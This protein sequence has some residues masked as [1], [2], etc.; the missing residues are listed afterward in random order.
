MFADKEVGVV[1]PDSNESVGREIVFIDSNVGDIQPWLQD[2]RPGSEIVVLDSARSGLAQIAAFMAGRSNIDAIHII[3]HGAQGQL[4]LGSDVLTPETLADHQTELAAIGRALSADGDILLYG[5]NIAAGTD[6][7]QTVDLLASLT[8]ADV[9]AS[10]DGT[11]ATAQGGDWTLEEQQGVIDARSLSAPAWDGLLV[12]TTINPSG[13]VQ[14]DG[15]D[16]LR[17][18]VTN[19]GQMQ[20]RYQNQLQFFSGSVTDTSTQLFNGMYMAVGTQVIGPDTGAENMAKVAWTSAGTQ[21]LTGTGTAADPFVVTTTMFYNANGV[22]GYQAAADTLA[23]VRTSYISGTAYFTNTVTITPP[24]TNTADIKWYQAADTLLG[25]TDAGPAYAVAPGIGSTTNVNDNISVI[26]TRQ[27]AGTASERFVGFAEVD[28][29][30]QFDRFY[31]GVYN[32][33]GLYGA[34]IAGGGN[35]T[36]T[37]TT[38][39]STDNGLGVQFNLGAINSATTFSYR[40][41]FDST[42]TLDLDANNSTATG[43][44]YV[45]TYGVGSGTPVKVVDS[46]VAVANVVADISR[47]T[48]TINN[49]QSGDTLS[50]SGALPA[51]ITA[52]IVGSTLTLT[53]SASEAAYQTALQQILFNSTSLSTV[54]RNLTIS[55]FNEI[56]S[57]ATTASATIN[58]AAAPVV[59]LNSGTNQ[60]QIITNGGFTTDLSGWTQTGT[61]G[62]LASSG[63]NGFAWTADNSTGTLRQTG[64]TGWNSGTAP[65]GA[66][67]LTFELGWN[68]RNPDT[69]AAATLDISVGGVVYARITTGINGSNTATITYMNGAS[70]S[71]ASVTSSTFGSWA[72]TGITINLPAT[73][74]ATGDL[75]FSYASGSGGDDIFIDGVSVQTVSDVTPGV[76]FTTTYTEN[77][78]GVSIADT[79][80]DVRDNDSTNMVSAR[81]VLTN[82]AAGDVL[83]VGSL[84]AGITASVDTSV[85]GQITVTLTGSATRASYAAAIRAITFSNTTDNPSTTPRTVNVTVN[86]GALDSAVA[87]TT[88]NVIAVNDA[89]VNTVPGARTTNE[90]ATL[91]ITGVS[92]ADPDS[93]TLTTTLTVTNGTL[94]VTAGGGATISGNGSATVTI[95]GTVAQINAALAGLT[96]INTPDYNGPAQLTISTNDGALTDT[97]T[98]A[99]TVTPVADITNDTVTTNE[100]TPITFN[101]ITGSNGASADSFENSGRVVTSVTQPAAG[102]GTVTFAADG[103]I[104][105][106]PPANF[107]G[108]TTFTYTVTSGGVTETATVTVNVTAVNDAPVNTVPAAQT[109]AEDTPKAIT[110]VSVA[111]VDSG[112]LTTTLSVTN[113]TLAVAAG[114]GAAITGNGSGT[115]TIVGTAAQINAALLGLTYT[116]TADYNGPAQLTVSTSD[117]ALTDVDTV[118]ITVTPVADITNDTVTTAEDTPI[119]FN[120]I[121]GTNGASADSFEN[122]GRAVT[123]VTQ[124][125]A[126]QGTVTFAADGTITYTPATNFNGVATFTYTVTSGGVTETATVTVNVTA[127]NDAPVNTV[128]GPQT[129]AEDTSLAIPGVS[130]SD[131]DNASLTTTLTVTNGTLSVTAGGGAT[132]A[133]NGSSVVT[134]AGTAAQINAALLGLTYTNTAD[135]NGPAQLT[136]STSDGALTD[137]DTVAITVTPVADITNDT[138]A[139]A[140]DTPISFN[141]ITGTNGAT[142]D[143]FEN[144]GRVVTSVTQPPAGQGTVT[145]AAD[146]TL[147]YTPAANFNGTTSFTYTVTSGGVTETATVTV[148][149]TAV[150][151][152]PVNTVPGPRTTAEDTPLAIAGVSV[153]DVDSGALT[154]TLTVTNGTLAV[155]AGGGATITGNGTGTVTVSGTAAQINAALAGL[156]Y[157]NTADYNGP[158]Q[159]TVSTSD[160]ALTDVDT[161]AI[162]V[163][164]VADIVN[165]T[166]TTAEDTPIT[167]NVITGTNGASVD[168][169]ENTGRVVTSVTQP[170]QGS[171]TFA[172]DG[173]IT[174]TPPAN[175]NGTTSF[176][177]TVTSGGVTETAT[178]TVNVTAVNDA[179]VNTVPAAQT[180]AEDTPLAITGVSVADVDSGALTTTLTVT[181]GTLAVT[182][183]GGATITGNGTGTVTVSGTAAQINAALLGLTYTN[184]A[185]YNGPA[186]LT[187]STSDGVLTDT[188][189]VAI[190]VTPVADITNDTVTTAEDTPITFNV[191]TGSNGASADSFENTGRVVSSV[192]QPAAGQGTVTFAADGTITYTP[193]SNFNGTTSF[194]YTVTSG[195]VTET[196]TVTLNVTAV[197]DAPVNTV[198]A[199]QT[200]AE[201]TPLAIPSV[202]VS[203][204]D[205]GTL[206]T[207][208]TVTNGTLT[209]TA[210]GGAGI[211]GN[212]GSTVTIT[213]TAAQI[214]AA[215]LGLTYTN[216]ADY[217]G[218]AQL[219]V[220]T[221]D[222][223]LTDTDTVGITVTPV[224]DITNDTVT[225]NEDTPITFNVIT[226]SNGATVDSFENAG[227]VVTS[228]TQPAAGQGTVTFA[229]D[230]TIT[231]TPAANFNGVATFTYTV[232]SGGVTETA[233]VTVNVT[234][235]ND[236]P[237]NTVPVAQ[238]TAEDTAL[239][240]GG[241]SV[242]DVDGGTLTTTLT[243]TSGTLTVATG[244]GAGIVGNGGST[245]TITGTAAQINAALLGLTYTNTADY[246]GPDTLTVSTTDGALTDTDTVAITVTPVADITND[247]VTT[248]EDTPITFNVIT[249]SDGATVDS[250]EN[251]GR[252]VT[253]VTQP[254]AGQGT[255]TF[256]A[257]GTITYT[258]AANFNGVATFTY[259]VTSGGVTETATVTVNV[260]AQ[261]DAPVN[262]VPAAQTTAEDTPLAIP[263]VSVSD[264]DGGPLTTTL[265][266]ANG[267]LSITAGGGAAVSGSGTATVTLSGT[268]AQINAALASLTYTNT[269]DYNG[270]DTL[271]VSTSDGALTDVDTVAIT[272]TPVVDVTND[273]VTTNEDAPISF[274][275]LTGTNGASADSFENSGRVV[276]SVT[277]PAAGQGTVTFAA[278]GTITYTPAAN[279][280]GT[281]TFTYTV[282]SGGVTETATVTVNVTAVND[283]PVNTVPATAQ[284]TEEDAPLA[285]GNVTVSD[286]DGGALTTTLTVANGTLAVA[287]G[288]GAG[289]T[290][291]GSGTVT[292]TGTAAQINAALLGLTYTNTADYNGP[293]TLTVSTSDGVLTDTDTVAITVTPVADITNDTVTTNEDTPITFNVLTGT[294]GASEDSFE[295]S[296]RAVT[297]VTQPPSG[298]GTVT[299]AADGT[300][301]YT[302]PADFN[303]TTSFTY[304][305]TSGGVTETATVTVNVTAQNDAPTN[306]VPGPRTTAEDSPLPISGVSVS[307]VD[308]GTL[309][310][311]LTVINGTLSV[312][313]SG[314]AVINGNGS[315]TVTITGTAAEINLALAGLTYTNTADYNGPDTLTV[316]TTDGALTDTDTVAITVTPV[317]DVTD[318]TV[319]TT[320]DTPITFNVITGS[321]GA[322]ADSFENDG[323]VVTSVTQPAPGQGTVTFAADGTITYTPPADFNGTTSFTYTVTSGGVTETATVTVNVTAANDAPVNTVPGPRTTAEDT[324]LAITGVSV[325]DVDSV[326]LTTT[327]TVT[328]GTLTVT[329]GGGAG[330]V[331]NGSNTV[332]LTGTAAQINAAL[333]G[334]TY[335]NTADYNGP[336]QLTVTTSDGAL[337]DVDTVAITVTPVDDIANDAVT[338]D[339]DTPVTISVLTNDS[340]ENPGRTITAVNG[341]SIVVGGSVTV[342]NGTVRLNGDGTLTFSP[343]LNFNGPTSFT[344][345]V[346][347]GGDTET[348]TVFVTVTAVEDAPVVTVPGPQETAEDTPLAIDS[349]RVTVFD[350]DDDPLTTTLTVQNGTL[351]VATG[352]GAG[353][354]GNGTGTVTITGTAAEINAAL[355][356]LTYTNVGDYNG[357]DLLQV[358]TN[359]GVLTD[360]ADVT[361]TVTAVAD[362]AGDN[363]NTDEDTEV[364]ISV[365]SNDSFENPGRAI[366]AV[367]GQAITANGPAIAVG[368]GTVRLNGAGQLIFLP[369]LDFTGPTSF[370][371][372]VT[373]GGVME[374]ASVTVDVGT[375][376][377]APVNTVPGVQTMAEDAALQITGVSVSDPDGAGEPLT[378]TLTV[379][380]GTLSVTEGGGATIAGNN[381]GTVTITGTAAQINA[382]LLGLTYR[383]TADYNGPAQLTVSTSDGALTDV[384]TVA[385]TVTPVRDIDN[386]AVTTAEDT[387]ATID[388]LANDSFENP[389]STITAINGQSIVVG[390][391]VAVANGTVRLNGDGT[392]T[393]SPTLNFNGEV[394]FTY[395]VTSGGRTETATVDVTVTAVN[396]AP[397]LTIPGAQTTDEDTPLDID[398]VRVTVFDADDDVLTTTLSVANGTVFVT[399]GG[400]A[401]V[402]ANGTATVTIVGT[403]TQVNAALAGLRYVNTGDYNGSDVMTVTV[404]DGT[405]DDG[406]TVAITVRPVADITNDTVTTAE[407]TPITFNV[408]TGSNGASAD[409]F[410]N[411]SRVVTS[412]TQPASGQGTVTFAADGTLTYTPPANFNG[413]TTFTYT[414]TSGG[415]TETATVTVNV[416]AVND[417]P[418]GTAPPATTL[419]DTP[420][421]GAVTAT[422]VDGDTLTFSLA[423]GPAQGT[424]L[425]NADGTYT[426]TPN[427]NYN[428]ADSFTVLVDDG[429]GGTT[430]VTVNVTVTPVNDNP[431]GTAPPVTTPEDTPV[432]GAVT[433][434]DVD[435]DTLTLSLAG[436]PAQGTVLVNADGTYTYTPNA[437]YNGPDSFTVLVDDGHGGTTTVTVNVTVTPENDAPVGTAPPAT[438]PEDTPVSGAVTA[439]DVDGDT[440]T[441]S[442]AGG[443]A[444]GTVLVNADGTYTYTPNANYNGPDSFTVLVDD[445][446][447]GTTTVTVN[448]TVTPV[449]D[450]PVATAPPVTTPE[451]TPV[452]G[453]V[454]ATDVDGDTL[455]FSLDSGPAQGTV[456][457]NA[458]GTYTYT[459]NANYNGADSFTVL[460]DDGHGGRTPVTVNVTVTPENDVPVNTVPVA[461]TTAEDALLSIPGV[462]VSDIDGGAL[463]TTL[464]VT[465]GTLTVA[466]GGGAGIV[467]NGGSTVTITGTA[468]EINLALAGLTYRNTADYNGPDTLTV[469]TTDGALTDTDTVGIT[470]SP[471]ADITDDTVTTDEDTPITFNVILGSNGATVDSFEN[472]GRVVTSVTQPAPGQGTVTFSADGTITYT[473]PA[474]FNGTTTFTYTVTSGGVTETATV[475]VNVTA[476]NDAP[477]NAVPGPQTTAED[478]P[479]SIPDV[480]VSDIDGGTLTTTLT[481]TNGTLS[482]TAGGG[483]L[484]SGSGTGTVVIEGTAAQINAALAGL[485]YRNTADYNGPA[486]LTVSTTDGATTDTDT[487]AITVT[488]VADITNDTVT[489][490]ED[491]PITFNV[492]T[493]SNGASE[494]SFENSG[495]VVTSVTQPAAGQGTV[496]FLAD[497]TITYT[498]PADFNG[499]TTFTYTVTSGGVTETATVTVNVTAQNDAPVNTV[500]GS[501]E[502][503]EDTLLAIGGVSV[504]D[505]DGGTLTTTLTVTNGTLSVATGGGAVINGN[506]GATVTITGTAAE[507]NLALAGLTYTNTADYNGPDTLTVSTS[508]GVLT[509]TDTVGIAVTPVTDI[510]NDTVTTDEDTPIT[511]NV[512]LGS[513]G[514]TVDSFENSGR[515]VSSV[516]QP[517][518]GQG[519][520]TFAADGTITYTP[521]A[522][523]NGTTTFTYTVTSG[524]VTET[525]TVTVNVTAVN[526]EP[527]NAVPG[528]QTTAED[529]LLSIPGVSVADVDGGTLTTTL[530][531]TSGTLTVATGGGAGIT[532][533]GSGTVTITGTAAD[534]NLALAGLTYRNTADYNGPDTLTVSTS[535]GVLTD[536]DTVGITVTPV[537]D[538]TDD[539]VTTNEDTPIT[540]NVITGSNGASEDSFENSGRVVTSVT[541]PAPGQG[542][543]VF[544]ADGTITYTPPADFNGTTTFTYTVTSGGVTETATVT[545]NVTA[546]NDA[547][548][549]AVPVAQTTAEDSPLPIPGVSVSD[550]DGGT[551][552]TTLT[553]ANGTLTVATGGGAGIV[554]NGGSTVT[555]TGTAL[556]INAALAGLIYTNTA[557]YNGPDTL[558]VSTSDGVLTDTDTVAITVTPVAD[559]TNDTVTTN[560]D[561]PI[562]FNVILG[563][564]G[565]TV[566]SFENSGRVVTSV[567]QPAPGQGTV[568]FSADGTITY[569]PP[570]DFNG[571]T[572]FTY[573]VTSG[574]VTETATVTVN[575]TAQNDAP[576]NTVPATAQETEEDAP[577]AIGGVTVSDVDGGTLTTTLTVT[578]GTLSVTAGGGALISGSGTGTVVI[579][580]T[581]AQINAALAG[582]TY[583]NTADYN[584][585]DTLTV[586][587]T[588]G[589]LTDTDTVAITVTPVADITNDT[590]TTNEDTPITFNVLTGT[591]GASADSFENAGHMVTAVTQPPPGQGSVSFAADGTI[592]YTPPVNF[593]GTTSFTYTVSS[594]GVTETATVTV[595]VTAVNDAPV[596]VIPGGPTL[597]P[598]QE[599]APVSIPGVTVS[600]ID[601]GSLTTTLSVA[602]GTLSVTTGGGAG[603]T[604]NGTGSVTITGTAAEINAA[605]AGLTYR[606][607]ADYNGPDTLTVSTSDGALDTTVTA[608]ITV[609]PVVDVT[610]D[611]V[612]TAED[613]PIS[614]NVLTGTNGAS[615][616]SF[617]NTGRVVTS[618]TQP[619]AGQGTVTFLADGTIT[620][621][622]PANFNGTTTFTYTVTSGGVTETATVTVNVASVNDAPVNTVPGPQETDEDAQ[623]AIPGVTVSDV[624]GD[625]LTTTLTVTNGTLSVAAGGGAGI[626]GEGTGT[627]TLTGTAAQINAAL[628]G[629]TYTNTADYNGPAQLTIS[630]TDGAA[631]DTDTVAITVRPVIDIDNDAVTTPEDTPATIDVLNNDSFENT[632]RT[633]V[634]INGQAI[635]VDGSVTVANGTVR[636]N[637]DNTLTFSPNLNFNGQITFTYSVASGGD[638]E[639]ATVTVTVTPVNDAPVVTVP[640]AQTTL[641]DRPLEVDGVR[642]IVIDA[643]DDALTTTVTVQNGTLTVSTGGGVV[644]SGNGTATVTI[645]G[646]AAQINAALAD[647]VYTSRADYNG[648]DQMQVRTSDGTLEGTGSVTIT[649]TPVADIDDDTVDTDEDTPVIV[650]VLT[651]DSFEN[652]GRAITAVDGQTITVGAT[653]N[654]ANGTV[655]LNGDGTLTFDPTDN[656][657]GVTSFTYTVTSGGVTE[658]ATVT[659]DVGGVNDTPQNT[660]PGPQPVTEDTLT[661]IPG[662]SVA[663]PDG[664]DELL[665][666]TLTVQNGTLSVTG[667]SGSGTSTV[668]LTGTAAQ[669]NA[670]LATLQYRGTADYNGPDQLRISTTDAGGLT[671]IDTV[672]ITVAPVRDI[673]DDSVVTREDTPIAISV[674]GNDTFSNPGRTITAVDGF[675]ITVGGPAI[676]VANGTV[677]LNSAGQLVFTPTAN[678]NGT[679]TFTYAVQSNGDSETATVTVNV[680]AENDPP[681]NTVPGAQETAEDTPLAIDGVRVS[682]FDAEDDA[683]TTTL[684]VL[685]GTLTVAAGSGAGV[686]GDGTGTVI[687]TGTAAQINAA[688][689]GLTYTSTAD[690]NGA[691]LMTVTTSDGILSDQDSVAITVRPAVDITSDAVTTLEDTPITFNVLT[692][693]NGASADTFTN[694]DRA[695]TAVTQPSVGQVTFAADG[696]LTY[697]PLA[698]FHGQVSFTYTV[699]SGGVTETATVTVNVTS[700]NDNPVVDPPPGPVTTVEDTPVSGRVTATDADGDALTYARDGGPA[701]GSVVV[702]LDGTYTYTPNPNYFGPDSFTVLVSDGNGGTTTV[703]INVTVTPV[704]DPPV[705]APV[706]ATTPEDTPVSGAVVATDP[707]G[708]ALTYSRA[709]DPSNGTVMVNADGTFIYTPNANYNGADSFTVL[710]DDGHGGTTTVAVSVTVTPVNDAP[711]G[712]A[713]PV[714][715]LEDTPVNGVV[716]GTDVDGDPLTFT[717]NGGPSQGTVVVNPDGTYTYTPNPNANGP[718]SFTVLVDDGNGGTTVVTVNVTVTPVN[719]TPVATAPPVTTSED[720]PVSGAV[721]ATDA[722][723]DPL[724]FTLDTGPTRGTVVINPD[725]T[726]TYTPNPNASG[727]DSFTVLVDDGQGG[728]T[729]VTVN[730]TVTPVNDVPVVTS[731]IATQTGTD[732]SAIRPLD[733]SA[734]FADADGEPLTY[735][736]TGL[737]PGLSLD[738]VTGV[739]SGTIDRSASLSGPFTVT[740]TATDPS[741]AAVSQTFTWDVANPAPL[742][743]SDSASTLQGEPTSG[744]VL[745]NDSDPD[746]DPLDVVAFTVGGITYTAGQ[747]ADIAGVGTLTIGADGS[748]AFTP[749][750]GFVGSVPSITYTVSDGQGGTASASL[751]ITVRANAADPIPLSDRHVP[752]LPDIDRRPDLGIARDPGIVVE[753]A[754]GLGSLGS[755]DG[756]PRVGNNIVVNVVNRI[757][758]L[759][760]V[761]S[762]DPTPQRNIIDTMT[763]PLFSAPERHGWIRPILSVHEIYG[764]S[765]RILVDGS[766]DRIAHAGPPLHVDVQQRPEDLRL[767]IGDD[768]SRLFH[769]SATLADGMP[770]PAGITIDEDQAITIRRDLVKQPLDLM[771][772]AQAGDQGDYQLLLTIDPADGR[773][774]ARHTRDVAAASATFD[775]IIFE[776]HQSTAR[777]AT[778]LMT[779]L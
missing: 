144:G 66:A 381:S 712:S 346:T 396:D 297:S 238:T 651:N 126:G 65:S 724:T 64:I 344:Y 289:I 650:S 541:Q 412:V 761:G 688:L 774:D 649:V 35:I 174:Y 555:I 662:L 362:I 431:V 560:E 762:M 226:G 314:G 590:V 561:T 70:G 485:T 512:I 550:V 440:L 102:Q 571:T 11:G 608:N 295:N 721:T 444:Q 40:I 579:E 46:D 338:T 292:I 16:G 706:T 225:T 750:A 655:R 419:E 75:L 458:D 85:A 98:V 692:G 310:T 97:D 534:I 91:A 298:Q 62:R 246:N 20:V 386:D 602:N 629:L 321:N 510:T 349:V 449:N 523:F 251:A 188:D 742:V 478:T 644:V 293:D 156:T 683:L 77:G 229:A 664:A 27:N 518:A 285:I 437:N 193:P 389:G 89:P 243:V 504:A 771:L 241:V 763:G 139:T 323:R 526:D 83:N 375:D 633:I 480:S 32:G 740:V 489:T 573:T 133:G 545:V 415:V 161:V 690:Y 175:F 312:G 699:T 181:N 551:L 106:T 707:E 19:L 754:N 61:G 566:D 6:G 484:I 472:S 736:A 218:P 228:V 755:I 184:T 569:T 533:N 574:G 86:D 80:N 451:D 562:T 658:T 280:N 315:S 599:D 466:T 417:D 520:V 151:D 689:A 554:G 758:R 379:T 709:S 165:D 24:S 328:N 213:G 60:T 10:T 92:I 254:A 422:D 494:D 245:V 230:G 433:A 350:A 584:G 360:S 303:G 271:T 659:V 351:T 500:P 652:P 393:F 57:D 443:P 493:G 558:T 734:G 406:G 100:D 596:V 322:S 487:V 648:P 178:V 224:A 26:A 756:P 69:A 159:L 345:S 723:G 592:T 5:C 704:N 208:L 732:G 354:T 668:V 767:A 308:S 9:A 490:N 446:H 391:D 682:V 535:D 483:A 96:Y 47:A 525:A 491:T 211:V 625:P 666:T 643:D 368:N 581:A 290:G 583:R 411:T 74:A 402:T 359:D 262:A 82:A 170:S 642:V 153:A 741:G 371:Y 477:V 693:T 264:V 469:S 447:G 604:G 180:T 286:V 108:T 777:L 394:S 614:F 718:D 639:T 617:E 17:I 619:P 59:D 595:N 313:T 701:N 401:T 79:D 448:V 416:T 278:D 505:V 296:G 670:A 4:D 320:E 601:S 326:S 409:S 492:I 260:T 37:I 67:Q 765:V 187:V 737:P 29:D 129:T 540:F 621:T 281:A 157:T 616:D 565:A 134:I 527:V 748:Y 101:V 110:G 299:F 195:G 476:Q 135:Y 436:G 51:G 200:T 563:S 685:H 383:N 103:T 613:T 441:F 186:Q 374:T 81:I 768:Q 162:T 464:T 669:I 408:I 410:E 221:S 301:T 331:G 233:T 528:P 757:D 45:T 378:T 255:V 8:S 250:F 210:G 521:P 414:V 698:N 34:G 719:D 335:T 216:T 71:P 716:I 145:F 471:V 14:T 76:N 725:G 172:A 727:P 530:T 600:D 376:N 576:V 547:P 744:N 352:G 661:P 28:G 279:F 779:E 557:D 439:T 15:S 93:S 99:I 745:A 339:E 380:N 482:V 160:G 463:T 361:I 355:A 607:T 717:L 332:V 307:D 672:A 167:F 529:A 357:P 544:A 334:L 367:N 183:G 681:V 747:M 714:T 336:A 122:A 760:V 206:T 196:A 455:T 638:V 575:V 33:S 696:T 641:E 220:S 507:I 496:T 567:T 513:N 423:G 751:A 778:N 434:T 388:V 222:G 95:S 770:L 118:G 691:D 404:S 738:P 488:P 261:N 598:V 258:P 30:R 58:V 687:L 317:A 749:V 236:A 25:G 700:V 239:A 259:T 537:A 294:N 620:Y 204:V 586:S 623:L 288:G 624:D 48:V 634:A 473:P 256:A 173:T 498:P 36:N 50:V 325:S 117:G 399:E 703:T 387:P 327:L 219:T 546:V 169:F 302:P 678:F 272:V 364:T 128:P 109:T 515:V 606:N 397:V 227:R 341:Q 612:T 365:L 124:P 370:T 773:I 398:G 72:R 73:V 304:T 12:Q 197:N 542:T 263:G 645:S 705:S 300:I 524:G 237:A 680:Q 372:T 468:A 21:T 733:V 618:V 182:A 120:V 268:A 775:Q 453:A 628:A 588:D 456:I 318:D 112:S 679:T 107:N 231:Y 697:T 564:N 146:G 115:V 87:T 593:N 677:S 291:N 358:V 653:V 428:G 702:N 405:L 552:T 140:E 163:T 390:G 189:T 470:V 104:T 591:N 55:V 42:T 342:V 54:S 509:D 611:S 267:T 425:V 166:V 435:G 149:V 730:V 445:G 442:L 460:V 695:V 119:S 766:G 235:Q 223:V 113:G 559:I 769:V 253:S 269:A 369:T 539:T 615:A 309:T 497:G 94:S 247:T 284:E 244:G 580:G 158:A 214:N 130:V 710:V 392:L 136:V 499:T 385:I 348:A 538:I 753:A 637:G 570:A 465:N 646:S 198:P 215:L 609:V 202:S 430:T 164:P 731:P 459:P 532:G 137:V 502:T 647:L 454:T 212:G 556:Q 517:P 316:S 121:T 549:N 627:V 18:H 353:I 22:A 548:V 640:G 78:A 311:T 735:T 676:A 519:T 84:P 356:G 772:F 726:Y 305:V 53:G 522:D 266:V 479:L 400:G 270:P 622:P 594:G 152:A 217:N 420:V 636:L 56:T 728:T 68:N 248:N 461:Q 274:N 273:E 31:S 209:V 481:V 673:V 587:T 177:Y 452:S 407:D 150:N 531:V 568:T 116:N 506:G 462:S 438:T 764:P 192:T 413:T 382:A 667:G 105:Y 373:S 234:A 631:T 242:S 111:D 671:D 138:V 660:V 265:T 13:G 123:S 377:D 495:R 2:I 632:G 654:V 343:T 739:V 746:G 713:Q 516:T 427:A 347:S 257:D 543:V 43:N 708:D 154:T 155:T 729:L 329:A 240:I 125:A 752:D 201:D 536:T 114:G 720:T 252:A 287:T 572:T 577:L 275:V 337:T 467:G 23:V 132:I 511:F 426:Y 743:Q 603:I 41:V 759:G 450:A 340:F 610:N 319:T 486:Q 578:S 501:Q 684:T 474:D 191:I 395:T 333:A 147:T 330:I 185:D 38:S 694:P 168:S 176:T 553:V 171:V 722:D 179:P 715:T 503:D 585:P 656:F 776:K 205:G 514:A 432:S 663:D 143:S 429:H 39:A 324:P 403:A 508:D 635:A 141:V 626:V 597:P 421:S 199:A 674:L 424:V 232:T 384:D 276:T 686:S 131:V 90:D 63:D 657:N 582:L 127:V 283:A 475:T 457:V 194:T 49:A 142:V 306:T 675:A 665:T 1:T 190:T 148:N 88:I 277:Q 7:A 630:T 3:S 711:T 605:L 44:D 52:S 418:V 366:T 249:G 282:T 203:D 589:A 363:A 207:T